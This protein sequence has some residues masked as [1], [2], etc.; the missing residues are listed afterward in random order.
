M[1]IKEEIEI[2]RERRQEEMKGERKIRKRRI[3]NK[4]G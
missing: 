2:K 4:D 3:Q 1:R